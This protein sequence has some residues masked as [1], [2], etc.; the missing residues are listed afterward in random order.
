VSVDYVKIDVGA[1]IATEI[2]LGGVERVFFLG[3]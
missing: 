2:N 1:K 3:G